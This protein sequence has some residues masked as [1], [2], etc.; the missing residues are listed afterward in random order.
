MMLSVL[1]DEGKMK[2]LVILKG[3]ITQHPNFLV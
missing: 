1:A 2:P 3:A